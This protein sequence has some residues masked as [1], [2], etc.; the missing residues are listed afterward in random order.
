MNADVLKKKKFTISVNFGPF[1]QSLHR[2]PFMLTKMEQFFKPKVI[3]KNSLRN[4]CCCYLFAYKKINWTSL[5]LVV[6]I[7][8]FTAI[9]ISQ[10]IIKSEIA[11]S[12]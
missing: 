11:A 5:F 4:C 6:T 9:K 7:T 3:C 1:F 2:L 8:D 10:T 12:P